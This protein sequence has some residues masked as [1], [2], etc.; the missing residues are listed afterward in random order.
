MMT[1]CTGNTVLMR[2]PQPSDSLYTEKA[3]MKIYDYNPERALL[4][5][6]SAEIVGNV[7][8]DRASFLRAR[9]FTMSPESMNFDSA[10]K[11]CQS[12]MQ[13]DYIKDDDN[14]ES[15][16]DLLVTISRRK[17]DFEQWLQWSTQKADFCRER[18]DEVEAL[19]TEAEVG[20]ILAYLGREE[21]GLQKLDDVIKQL[22]GVRKFNEMDACIIALRRKVDVLQLFERFAE[23][24]PIANKII[25]KTN[26]FEQHRDEYHDGSFREPSAANVPDYC[27]FY[28]VKAFAYLARSYAETDD[29][30]NARYYLD[31]FENSKYGKSFDGRMMISLTWFKLG[32]Y[33]KMNAVYDDYEKKQDGDTISETY[34]T[35]LYHRAVAANER[36]EYIKAY[37]YMKRNAE[38]NQLINS[39]LQESKAQEYAARYRA[40]EQQ[41]EIERN[42]IQNRMQNIII[43]T[44]FVALVLI[45]FIYNRTVFQ[46]RKLVEKNAALVR[47][48][49]ERTKQDLM[50]KTSE[51]K[52]NKKLFEVCRMLREQPDMAIS[53]IAKKV[54]MTVGNMNKIFHEQYSM[55]P[56]E[57]RKSHK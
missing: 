6:D 16:L 21:E 57:Y 46:K 7:T 8:H 45:I 3:A 40:Q 13:S 28:R 19:R 22:D 39:Q 4:I 18:G 14:R 50:P 12:L 43:V 35:I 41:M 47:L 52:E 38:L 53:A 37:D 49:D 36:G 20:V 9:V 34:S 24:I 1:G 2:E 10:Q 48:I 15:V 30:K 17:Q 27:E 11:I 51:D 23:I 42:A 26:D 25:E 31:F 29:V 32:D 44:L 54:G 5:I 55:S 33:D 56:T